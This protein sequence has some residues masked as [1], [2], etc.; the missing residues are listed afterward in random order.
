MVEE[1]DDEAFETISMVQECVSEYR[2]V[3]DTNGGVSIIIDVPKRFVSLWLLKL[4]DLRTDAL[5][6]SRY[7]GD[8]P[9]IE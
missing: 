7:E 4:H 5:E 2:V 1:W 3:D 8:G 6:I 9:A